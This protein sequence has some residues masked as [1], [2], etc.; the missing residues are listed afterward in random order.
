MA[1]RTSPDALVVETEPAGSDPLV[2]AALIDQLDDAVIATAPDGTVRVWNA[3]ARL[4]TGHPAEE[5]MGRRLADLVD[6]D[7]D[8]PLAELV[9]AAGRGRSAQRTTT[10]R[11]RDGGGVEVAATVAPVPGPG[12]GARGALVVARPAGHERAAEAKFRAVVES[13]PDAMV[14]VD[15]GG[16]ITLVNAQTEQLFGWPREELVGRPVEVLVPE[17]LRARHPDHRAGYVQRPRVR[18]MGAGLE[19]YG[20]RKDGHEFPVEISLSP[21]RTEGGRLVSAAIRDVTERRRAERALAEAYERE[22]EAGHRLRE[23]DRMKSDF[24][25]TV[26]HE[27]RT[28]LTSIKGYAQTLTAKWDR[29]EDRRRHE[30]VGRITAASLK[31]DQLIAEL[32]DFTRLERGQLAIALHPHPVAAL[33]TPVLDNLREVAQDHELDVDV[34]R[35]VAVLANEHAFGRALENLLT[36]AAKFSDRGSRI[37]VRARANGD[38]EV[39]VEVTDQG[40]G[41]GA[42]ELDRIFDRFYRVPDPLRGAPGTGIG[43]AIVKEYVEAQGGRVEVRSTPGGGSTFVITLR[44]AP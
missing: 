39:A 1:S 22:R 2:L 31:L 44:A 28:P 35:D 12:G 40:I 29:L 14:L 16:R 26:S 4:L 6:D 21:I 7:G 27:L 30:L 9:E 17:R 11:H 34:P 5:A 3:T 10:W 33:V 25:A 32:L 43:L 13:A 36:N 20:L 15:E 24:L 19:L 37:T 18:P 23:L 42:D 38:G 8:P 41:V